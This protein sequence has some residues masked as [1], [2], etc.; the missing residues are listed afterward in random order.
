M[1]LTEIASISNN[2]TDEIL[3]TNVIK[4]FVNG[5][6]SK[7]NITLKSTLPLIDDVLT[8]TAISDD[9]QNTVIVPYVCWSIKMNDS[10]TN[11]ANMFLY[12]YES[13]LRELK[14]N[15]QTAIAEDYQGDSFKTV[16]KITNYTGM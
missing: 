13:G 12:Q 14:K 5:A 8:Y 11:E 2:Y 16:Y 7:I 4:S 10:S 9:W 6:I 3:S 1:T 15:K